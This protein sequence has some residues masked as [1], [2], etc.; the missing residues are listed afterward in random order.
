MDGAMGTM[1]QSL[2]LTDQVFGG[3]D[4][5]MLTD[6]L[7]FSRPSDL[8]KIHL[9]YLKAGA[10]LLETNTFGASPL[11]LGEFDFKTIDPSDMQGIPPGLEL[12]GVD[13][14][15]LCAKNTVRPGAALMWNGRC[16]M[17]MV[18]R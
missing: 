2:S 10:N 15:I 16:S 5:K 11:R 13:V 17:K 18:N 1:V 9:E 6:L 14:E 12:K 4:F 7:V 3:A 8:E